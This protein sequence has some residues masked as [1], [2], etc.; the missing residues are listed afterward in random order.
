MKK[1][2]LGLVALAVIGAAT[3][4]FSAHLPR[5]MPRNGGQ[6]PKRATKGKS[7]DAQRLAAAE[8]KRE[9]RV[10]RNMENANE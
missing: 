7:A 4:T 9:R 3:N 6:S 1:S 5:V 8:A 2:T 10:K